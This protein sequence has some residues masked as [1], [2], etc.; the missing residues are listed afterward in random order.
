MKKFYAILFFVFG[1]I[2]LSNAQ[3][4]F[5]GD[6]LLFENFE[7]DITPYIITAF[8]SGSDATWINADIDQLADGSGAGR[9]GEWYQGNAWAYVD[10]P[11]VVMVGNS[12]T[13]DA[14]QWVA[15][16]LILPP[17]HFSDASG[18]LFWKSAPYQTPRYLDGYMV[19]AST[20]TNDATQ[21][22]D[23]LKKFAEF[24]SGLPAG[25]STFSNYQ[26]SQGFVHGLDGQF[27]E[28]HNDSMRFRG[29]L[30]TDSVSLAA[31]AGETV[32]IAFFQGTHDDNL[33]ALD[34]ICVRGA[35]NV[36]VEN[37][38][39]EIKISV[40]PNPANDQITLQYYLSKSSLV[41]ISIQDIA[42]KEIK[43]LMKCG[44]INGNYSFNFN[45]K[46]MPSGVYNVVVKSA[47]GN[48]VEKFVKQ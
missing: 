8:P 33:L 11:N 43:H 44:Q 2:S 48:L 19:L 6:T 28:Y 39:P 18:K 22:A 30:R 4:R 12:W 35:G 26:F 21:F 32:Y 5:S 14:S 31:Y 47:S 34:D 1:T 27:I 20:N 37:V 23:T 45:V 10:T 7:G 41:E 36:A 17:I 46:D 9:P 24:I 25:D 13:N 3:E 38:N 42:G 16:F 29:V 15:N 40:F